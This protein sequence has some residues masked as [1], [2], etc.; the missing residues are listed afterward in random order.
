M[1]KEEYELYLGQQE[2]ERREK[3]WKDS[4]VNHYKNLVSNYIVFQK[5]LT[6]KE[7]M[8]MRMKHMKNTINEEVTVNEIVK[9]IHKLGNGENKKV[10]LVENGEYFYLDGIEVDN[11][12]DIVIK[13]GSGV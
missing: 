11:D 4:E 3:E 6:I 1:D 10:Y 9:Q 7:E 13:I 2:I 12:G 8:E 5:E